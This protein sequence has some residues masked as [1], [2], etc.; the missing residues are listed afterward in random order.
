MKPISIYIHIPFCIKKCHYCDFLSA[1]ATSRTQEDYLCA[2]KQEIITQ[3]A[4]YDDYEVQTIFIGGGTPTVVSADSLCKILFILRQYYHV[5]SDAE[6]SMEANPGTVTEESLQ[7]YLNAGINRLS[8]GLQSADNNELKCLGRIHTYEDFLHSYE[9]AVNV[10]FHN[11]NVD[12]M[13]ALPGQKPFNYQNTLNK[14]ISLSPRPTHIS[15]YSLIIEEG[16]FFYQLYGDESEA[17]E[18]TGETQPHLPSEKD[19]RIMYESTEKVLKSAGYHRYEISNYSLPGYECRHNKVYWQRGNYVGFGLGAS[20]MVNNQ[21]FQNI[22]DLKDY[23]IEPG[24]RMT[25]Q[26]LSKEEQMSEFMFLGLRLMKG[27]SKEDFYTYFGISMD[28]VYGNV[29]EKN[30]QEGL[31]RNGRR[32]TLTKRG[33]SLSNMV[34][35]QFLL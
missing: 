25:K 14:I 33:I 31:L 20:S 15:A 24:E 7:L 17:M 11:I 30:A 28:D 13:S 8:F 34:M 29:L 2:L 21:R 23:L 12:L 10:G 27:V 18:R 26:L 6:I 35:A 22:S 5:S 32:V 19:E 4:F 9:M 16:T 1:P 3:A